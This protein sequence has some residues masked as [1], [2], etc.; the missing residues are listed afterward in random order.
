MVFS[1]R[2]PLTSLAIYETSRVILEV[3]SGDLLSRRLG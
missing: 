3:A 2:E 1:R